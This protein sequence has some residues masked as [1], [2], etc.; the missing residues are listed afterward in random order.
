MSK[1]FKNWK[2]KIMNYTIISLGGSI[3]IPTTGFNLEF[4][5]KFRQLIINR[6]KKGDCFVFVVGGG[7]TCRAYQAAAKAVASLSDTDLDWLGIHTTWYNAEFVRLL[8]GDLAHKE[9]IKNPTIKIKTNKPII[10]AGGWKP[11]CSTDFDAVLFAENFGAKRLI[12]A[13]NIDYVYTADPKLDQTAQPLKQMSWNQLQ[14]IVGDKW[15]PG[16]NVPFDP[17]ATKKA[18][19]LGL[20]L[21][22]VKG[23]NLKQFEKAIKNVKIDGTIVE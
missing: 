1:L 20:Q 3:V 17:K 4:L 2:L 11:G 22:F 12:N 6:V 8:F 18:N 13:S 14:Q 21:L 9:V 15:R 5:K 23:N 19:H 16:A 10:V 7:A